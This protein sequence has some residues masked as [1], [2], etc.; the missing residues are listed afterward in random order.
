MGI[1]MAIF[2]VG[3]VFAMIWSKGARLVGLALAGLCL[4]AFLIFLGAAWH[5]EHQDNS[6]AIEEY[7]AKWHPEETQAGKQ[8]AALHMQEQ[9]AGLKKLGHRD[10]ATVVGGGE[11]EYRLDHQGGNIAVAEVGDRVIVLRRAVKDSRW[12]QPLALESD[13]W[14]V[15]TASGT[16]G[17]MRFGSNLKLDDGVICD[18]KSCRRL[19]S[20]E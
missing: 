3:I 12:G 9:E 15:Q 2:I 8:T 5:M 16:K 19:S 4:I 7:N 6:A 13:T 20:P 14:F 1:G 18:T 11:I 10:N 17:Y